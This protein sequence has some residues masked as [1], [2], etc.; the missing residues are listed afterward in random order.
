[1]VSFPK[2]SPNQMLVPKKLPQRN[3]TEDVPSGADNDLELVWLQ[4]RNK[5][6]NICK[7]LEGG[8]D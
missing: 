5:T 1:M 3:S 8:E 7:G 2:Q 4:V 6:V